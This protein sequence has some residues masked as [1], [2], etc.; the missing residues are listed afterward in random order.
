VA[1]I[2]QFLAMNKDEDTIALSRRTVGDMREANCFAS[3][4]RKH[5]QR[6]LTACSE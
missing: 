4:S 1:L 5:Q 3:A 6:T 2:E